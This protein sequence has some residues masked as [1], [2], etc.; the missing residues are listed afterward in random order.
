[1]SIFGGSTE[2]EGFG[3]RRIALVGTSRPPSSPP[4][5][6][7]RMPHDDPQPIIDFRLMNPPTPAV[8]P[9]AQA[10]RCAEQLKAVAD[11]QRLQILGTLLAG[12]KTVGDITAM[13]GGDLAKV[14]HHLGVLRHAKLATA[15]KRGRFVVYALN[16]AATLEPGEGAAEYSVDLGCCRFLLPA[17]SAESA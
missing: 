1:M 17:P 11:P 14:S 9:R 7:Y 16:P 3:P 5:P 6:A 12:P 15:T 8:D 2:T 10:A 4:P 13:I